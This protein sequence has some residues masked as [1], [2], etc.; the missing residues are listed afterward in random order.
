MT[1]LL[2]ERGSLGGLYVVFSTLAHIVNVE[3]S[4]FRKTFRTT[5]VLAGV[6]DTIPDLTCLDMTP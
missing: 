2:V 5:F 6:S 4:S 3:V 1:G